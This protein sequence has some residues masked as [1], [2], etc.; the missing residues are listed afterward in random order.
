[1]IISTVDDDHLQ[2]NSVVVAG[3]IIRLLQPWGSQG[4]GVGKPTG[5]VFRINSISATNNIIVETDQG[6]EQFG[7][8]TADNSTRGLLWEKVVL[9]TSSGSTGSSGSS[10]GGSSN[11]TLLISDIYSHKST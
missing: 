4:N 2:D 5:T 9:A 7:V 10:G 6:N 8:I 1:M 3:D 11:S